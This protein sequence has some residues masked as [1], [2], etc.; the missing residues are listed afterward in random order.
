MSIIYE[1]LKKTEKIIHT[2]LKSPVEA[3]PEKSKKLPLMK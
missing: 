2:D 3:K 1:A